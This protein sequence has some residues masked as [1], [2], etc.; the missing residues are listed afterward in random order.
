VDIDEKAVEVTKLSL[1]LK[2]MEG[3]T[4]ETSRMLISG[5]DAK[6]L[7]NLEDNIKCGNSLIGTDYWNNQKEI[8]NLEEI[9]KMHA[10]DWEKQFENVFKQ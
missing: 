5:R 9:K 2:L 1:L 10:F 4:K 6:I 8:P 7:P 3:E